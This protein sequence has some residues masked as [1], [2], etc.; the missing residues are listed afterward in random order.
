MQIYIVVDVLYTEQ[1]PAI[2]S[3]S[4]SYLASLQ[5]YQSLSYLQLTN[6][7]LVLSTYILYHIRIINALVSSYPSLQ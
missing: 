1:S 5:P 7:Y 3:G 6:W 2:A 4:F